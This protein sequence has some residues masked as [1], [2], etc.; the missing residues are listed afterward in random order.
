MP[1]AAAVVVPEGPLLAPNTV[2][3]QLLSWAQLRIGHFSEAV[4]A[5]ARS[6]ADLPA[7]WGALTDLAQDPVARTRGLDAAWKLLLVTAIALAAQWAARQALAGQRRRLDLAAPAPGATW[8]WFRRLPLVLGRLVLDLVP[9]AGFALAVYGLLGLLHPL[10]TTQLVGLL[11]GHLYIGAS[12]AYALAR[13]L[14]S[15]ASEH[16][17]LIP[18][19]DEAAAWCTLWLR[20]ML[21]V[22]LGGYALAEA[23]L[24]LGLSWSA[25]DTILNLALLVISLF[26]VLM[27]LQ[28][29]GTIAAAL[30]APA[31]SGT[32]RPNRARHSLRRLRDG[33]AE[34]W[35]LLAIL[36]LL[37]LW[38][39]WALAIP[40]GFHL[41]FRWTAVTLLVLG[42][43]KAL[44]EGARR[45]L[46]GALTPSPELA[47][48][49]PGLPARAARYGPLL[50]AVASVAIGVG[51]VLVL[52]E[53]WGLD[54]FGWFSGAALGARLLSTLG[55]IGA[56]LVV[57]VLVWEAANA[58]IQRRLARLSQDSHA[59]R[60]ARVRTL[61]PMLRTALG[62]VIFVFVLLDTLAQLG[63]NVAPLLAGAGV[64]GLAV[65]FGSQTLVRDVI[66]GIFLLLEDAVAVGDVVQLGGLSGVVE[67]LSIRSIKLRALDGSVHIVPFSA[68][69]TVTNMT[70]DFSFAVL[71][72]MVG[73]GEDTD[74][75]AEVLKE[76][77]QQMRAEPKWHGQMRDDIDI[78]G[79]EQLTNSGV[80]IRARVKTEP[81][82]R[83]NV[84]RE[85]NRRIKRRF[86]ELGIEIP[87]PRQ[88][89]MLERPRAPLALRQRA[90]E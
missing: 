72:V 46:D 26:A 89:L 36:W 15:P 11:L 59:A 71:D 47:R 9:V 32:A 28:Q 35:H 80:M 64:I 88:K 21:L 44:D 30:R 62:I 49:Y 56:T 54:A 74:H 58:G 67:Q 45:L 1:G 18:C 4:L 23:G 42:L 77:A 37:A 52:L 13:M 14:L 38:T 34:V 70:R 85:F 66:T 27:I 69:T 6:I 60:S 83:W 78:W 19:S 82:A 73:Y 53:S 65:G 24:L 22:G 57:A 41:L 8:R 75:V 90:A 29:R 79:V 51:A 87:Y 81:A 55:S 12:I 33:F 7:L 61:L 39:V 86:D 5:A 31:L 76:I 10:P 63:V 84:A 48:R 17:R 25:Y 43:A 16:L 40:N 3:A 2:G 20:R 68:V 50:K